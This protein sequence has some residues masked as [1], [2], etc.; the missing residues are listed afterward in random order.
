VQAGL[1]ELGRTEFDPV[2]GRTRLDFVCILGLL[3]A[4]RRELA[5]PTPRQR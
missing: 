3:E 5:N 4:A 1:G 2:L